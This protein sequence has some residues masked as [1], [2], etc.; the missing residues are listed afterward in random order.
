MAVRAK[1][2]PY[3][4]LGPHRHRG[5][6]RRHDSLSGWHRMRTGSRTKG[7]R[8]YDRAMPEVTSD[9]T[10][11]GHPGGHSVVLARRH[12]NTGTLS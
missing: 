6:R 12:C 3:Y 10:P 2:R 7:N 5:Q 4:W 9:D 1:P 11:D 8:H